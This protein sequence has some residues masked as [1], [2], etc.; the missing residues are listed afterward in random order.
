MSLFDS[1][2]GYPLSDVWDGSTYSV[3]SIIPH[4]TTADAKISILDEYIGCYYD[5]ESFGVEE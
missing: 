5:A 2:S 4:G 3:L 1:A